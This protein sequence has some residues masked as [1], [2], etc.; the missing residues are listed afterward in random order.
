ME[1]EFEGIPTFLDSYLEDLVFEKFRIEMQQTNLEEKD[2]SADLQQKFHMLS[3]L[4]NNILENILNIHDPE[5]YSEEGS[6]IE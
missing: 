4:K 2:L 3:E 5:D 1:D 6:D